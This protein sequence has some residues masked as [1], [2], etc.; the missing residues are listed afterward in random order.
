MLVGVKENWAPRAGSRRVGVLSKIQ[1]PVSRSR[2]EVVVRGFPELLPR[3]SE[4]CRTLLPRPGSGP[5][6][7]PFPACS[8]PGSEPGQGLHVIVGAQGLR[9]REEAEVPEGACL[10]MLPA[11]FLPGPHNRNPCLVRICKLLFPT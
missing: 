4:A 2:K 3:Q 5:A 7:S 8:G 1:G 10:Q 9:P 6:S 11:V